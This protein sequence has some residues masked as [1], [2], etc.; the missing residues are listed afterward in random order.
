M[1]VSRAHGPPLSKLLLYGPHG[2]GLAPFQMGRGP[3]WSSLRSPWPI[4]SAAPAVYDRV[5]NSFERPKTAVLDLYQ[6][7]ASSMTYITS[8]FR[9]SCSSN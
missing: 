5:V 1:G 2:V 9:D 7:Y 3:L 4:P 6:F 8:S